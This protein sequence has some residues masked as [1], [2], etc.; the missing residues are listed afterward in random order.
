MQISSASNSTISD[1]RAGLKDF[2]RLKKIPEPL[3]SEIEEYFS[4]ALDE[5]SLDDEF[6]ILAWWK[7]NAP[8][9]PIL[10]RLIRD[11][12]AVPISTVVGH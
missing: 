9:Y 2:I 11:I 3:K 4:D 8:K 6:D 10:A 12:L 5:T 1:T 7:L